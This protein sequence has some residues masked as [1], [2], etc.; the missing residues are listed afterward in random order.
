MT[1]NEI[2]ESG[3]K[4]SLRA[5]F[6]FN[7]EDTDK[8]VIVKFNLW[9]RYFFPKYFTSIDAKFHKEIDQ[10][11]L[12]VY[13]G[14]LESFIDVAFRGAAK[15]ARTKLFM[16][17]VILNDIDQS[18]RY[19]KVLC[20]DKA[21]S[22][23]IVTDVYNMLVNNLIVQLYPETFE[24]TTTKREETMASFTTAT[25]IKMTAGT[26]GTNQR[27]A[28]QEDA[29]PDL[30]WY[31]DFESR[32][33]LRSARKTK[34][35]WENMEE[36][37]TGLAKGGGCIYTCNYV[38]EQGNVH[39]LVTAPATRRRVLI[40]PIIENG[41]PTWVRYS[42]EDIEQMRRDDDDFEGE[43]L[44]RPSASKDVLFDRETLDKMERLEP[45]KEVAGFRIY[46][47]YDPSHRYAFGADVAG[48]I[49]LDSSTSCVIDFE[50]IP[51]HVT[52]TFNNNNIKPMTFGDELARQGNMF[53]EALIAP[54]RNNH[55]HATIGR[56]RQIYDNIFSPPI[57]ETKVDQSVSQSKE[58]GWL[59]TGL[60]KPKM[61]FALSRAVE[62]GHL[63]LNDP[64][65]IQECASYSRNDLIDSEND[66]RLTTRHFDLLIAAAIAWQMKDY[67]KH[68]SIKDEQY[69]S[70]LEEVK[71]L[72]ADIGM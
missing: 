10:G 13:R 70:I 2:I 15:T 48:G 14:K 39:K 34:S 58:Y 18:H 32:T 55:G 47:K 8:L 61:I 57:K 53:G 56:L 3:N 31:E 29:R 9:S 1:V 26:V 6:S 35:I 33:T 43:R 28:L 21:N 72:Y 71:P 59:T 60:S 24:K 23:Q 30:I 20:E 62:D 7:S 41:V 54:E 52:G 4:G 63:L 45:I 68:P 36:A 37:R 25:S 67:A 42:L 11:N 50:T 19:F 46:K 38:S 64:I 49:G 16:G 66:P 40:I 27:G 17:F 5:L 12:D 69:D 22:A 44:C 51:A 65:L